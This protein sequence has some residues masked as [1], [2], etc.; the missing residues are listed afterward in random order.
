MERIFSESVERKLMTAEKVAQLWQ[1]ITFT[2]DLG[3]LGDAE[4]VVEA[5]FEDREVKR[6]LYP[7]LERACPA[8]AC[9]RPTRRRTRSAS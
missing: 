2:T 5:V 7:E 6:K 3:A 9:W 1:T 8:A 4:L